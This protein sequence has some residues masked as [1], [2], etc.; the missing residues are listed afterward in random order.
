MPLIWLGMSARPVSGRP[1]LS[2][3]LTHLFLQSEED[4]VHA[5]SQDHLLLVYGD[6][7]RAVAV[8]P[9]QPAVLLPDA[10]PD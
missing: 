10:G 5:C 2:K 8:C 1:L 6:R 4:L 9:E 7:I 3:Y